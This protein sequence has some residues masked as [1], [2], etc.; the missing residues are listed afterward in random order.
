MSPARR[1]RIHHVTRYSYDQQMEACYNRAVLRPRATAHQQVVSATVTLSPEPELVSEHLDYFGNHSLYL[2]TRTA[3]T[4]LEVV[5]EH[6]VVV[7]RPRPVAADLNSWTVA[8]AVAWAREQADPLELVDFGLPSPLVEITGEVRRFAGTAFGPETAL[9]DALTGLLAT[10][11]AELRYAQ[12]S[13]SVKTTLSQLL[14]LRQGVCQDFAHLA[15]GCLRS[16][17][18]PTRYVSGYLETIPAPGAVKLRGADATHAWVSVLTPQ[19][20][21]DLDPTND[22]FVGSAHIVTAWGRDFSDVSPLR[23]VV[24]TEAAESALHVAVDVESEVTD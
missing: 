16:A 14:E 24:L 1:Y 19:G 21:V 12:G 7:D 13:T 11:G 22:Q 17:G 6:V 8:Q 3:A 4:E 10:I 9:G 20:W 23:G 5:A 18:L 2:E 15:A